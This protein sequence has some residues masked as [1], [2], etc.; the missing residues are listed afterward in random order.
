M[1][2]ELIKIIGSNCPIGRK[3]MKQ[4][5]NVCKNNHKEVTILELNRNKDKLDY[6][7]NMVPAIVVDDKIISQGKTLSDKELKRLILSMSN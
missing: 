6:N 7:I 3:L 5:K 2:Y 1:I 4:I